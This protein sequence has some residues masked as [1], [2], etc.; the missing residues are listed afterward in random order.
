MKYIFPEVRILVFAKAPLEGQ[1]KTRLVP[2]L[3][4]SRALDLHC[5]MV[6]YQIRRVIEGNIA[7]MELWVSSNPSHAFFQSLCEKAHIYE[8]RGNDLGQRMLHAVK[9]AL[10]RGDS[11]LLV[12]TDCPSVD[13][14]YLEQAMGLLQ[15]GV[16]VIL[17]PAED[18]GYVLIG[19]NQTHPELFRDI[20]WG[21]DQVMA[22]TVERIISAGLSYKSLETR[23]DVDR[24]EDLVRL[25]TLQPPLVF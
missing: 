15:Q 18:G 11:V 8:Q 19:M 21:S 16:D 2:E 7:P 24:P 6:A 3:G 23:W 9:S 5:A 14:Q 4:T 1:V 20:S 17:G 13:Q 22:S 10:Q 12:G 25:K